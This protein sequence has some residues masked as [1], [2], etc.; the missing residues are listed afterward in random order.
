MYCAYKGGDDDSGGK[1]VHGQTDILSDQSHQ[2]TDH[3]VVIVEGR[4]ASSKGT[5]G[6]SFTFPVCFC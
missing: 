6:V 1:D 5:I 2:K 4:E 3:L